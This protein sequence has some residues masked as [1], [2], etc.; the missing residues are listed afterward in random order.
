M[1]DSWSKEKT[2]KVA[3]WN[4]VAYMAFWNRKW[5][6]GTTKARQIKCVFVHIMYQYSFNYGKSI[7]L[8]QNAG[9]NRN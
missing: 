3:K 6:V 2:H 9:V 7:T 4:V 5:V 8:I 1:K